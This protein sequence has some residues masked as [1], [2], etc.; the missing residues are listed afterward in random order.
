MKGMNP[1]LTNKI[2]SSRKLEVYSLLGQ[3]IGL[4]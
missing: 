3:R 4:G 2:F 1:M